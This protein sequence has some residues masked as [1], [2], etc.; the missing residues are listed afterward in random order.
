MNLSRL[1]PVSLIASTLAVAV[2]HIGPA[3]VMPTSL[4]ASRVA[5]QSDAPVPS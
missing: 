4:F 3:E 5:R 1:F 2:A